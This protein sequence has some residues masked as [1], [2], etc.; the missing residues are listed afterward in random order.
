MPGTIEF[1]SHQKFNPSKVFVLT[2]PLEQVTEG[3]H[4]VDEQRA[5][6]ALLRL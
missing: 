2:L 1:R 4:A 3:Y 5:F 6:K